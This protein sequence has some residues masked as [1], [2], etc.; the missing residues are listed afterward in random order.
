MLAGSHAGNTYN[1]SV[2]VA[3]GANLRE[4]GRQM[5]EA[6]RVFEQGSGNSWRT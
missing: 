4:A 1:I 6:I 2:N 3:P 5:V